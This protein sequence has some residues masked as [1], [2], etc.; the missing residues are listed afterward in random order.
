MSF[1][2]GIFIESRQQLSNCQV[3]SENNSSDVEDLWDNLRPDMPTTQSRTPPSSTSKN[4]AS[5]QSGLTNVESISKNT[6]T[7]SESDQ[8]RTNSPKSVC[9]PS[10]STTNHHSAQSDIAPKKYGRKA[11]T[12]VISEYF[13]LKKKYQ[14]NKIPKQLPKT[15]HLSKFFA[16]MEESVRNLPPFLQIEAKTK[17]SNIVLELEAKAIRNE[18]CQAP[19]WTSTSDQHQHQGYQQQGYQQQGFHQQGYQQQGY[20]QPWYHEY[21]HQPPTESTSLPS[22]EQALVTPTARDGKNEK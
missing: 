1:L 21:Q 17:I 4:L 3:E 20:Q 6:G 12:S 13:N 14:E 16:A 19:S 22:E 10:T 5:P 15:D 2:N 18:T 7:S 9:I 8:T 11:R